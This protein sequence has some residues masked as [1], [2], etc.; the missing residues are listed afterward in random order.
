MT[1]YQNLP[2][3]VRGG[4]GSSLKD[5]SPGERYRA[6]DQ[7]ILLFIL[8]QSGIVP[9]GQARLRSVCT[10]LSKGDPCAKPPFPRHAVRPYM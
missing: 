1:G 2:T 3:R 10:A 9:R 7:Q 5:T 8:Q 4:V 6:D